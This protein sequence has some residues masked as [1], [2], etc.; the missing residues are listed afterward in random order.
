MGACETTPTTTHD[1]GSQQATSAQD[2]PTGRWPASSVPIIGRRP[3][4]SSSFVLA[5]A[6]QAQHR[7]RALQLDSARA[8]A[9]TG[10]DEESHNNSPHPQPGGRRSG[11]PGQFSTAS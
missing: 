5:C 9:Q 8:T 7:L 3:A 2:Y 6:F 1:R 4:A 11:S 10:S